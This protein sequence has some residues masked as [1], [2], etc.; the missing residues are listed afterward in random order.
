MSYTFAI[1]K[2]VRIHPTL[3][4]EPTLIICV[5]WSNAAVLTAGGD[6]DVVKQILGVHE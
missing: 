3:N 2:S 6:G 5:A 4:K 1:I